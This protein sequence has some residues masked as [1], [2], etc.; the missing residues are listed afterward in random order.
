M[1]KCTGRREDATVE[2]DYLACARQTDPT[3]A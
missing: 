2:L 1:P 3:A